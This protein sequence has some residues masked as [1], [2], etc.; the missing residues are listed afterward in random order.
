V[1]KLIPARQSPRDLNV[2]DP[3][4]QL[5]LET[6]MLCRRDVEEHFPVNRRLSTWT[7]LL[8]TLGRKLYREPK[9]F[10]RGR[11]PIKV[12]TQG[13]DQGPSRNEGTGAEM[14][15]GSFRF[16]VSCGSILMEWQR[17]RGGEMSQAA[18][19]NAVVERV[20]RVARAD[21]RERIQA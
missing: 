6:W 17:S 21:D 20:I 3:I 15:F 19:V 5:Y 8:E 9:V 18:H 11:P 13:C 16:L 7:T 10:G 14:R 4:R 12:A 2:A 1:V